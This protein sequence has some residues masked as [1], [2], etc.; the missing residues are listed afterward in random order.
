MP[1]KRLI[2]N[3][4]L[5]ASCLPD[6]P[7]GMSHKITMHTA[8]V[9]K[10][11]LVYPPTYAPLSRPEGGETTWGFVKSTGAV[12]RPKNFKTPGDEVCHI[13]DAGELSG[14]TSI[15]PTCTDLTHL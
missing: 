8:R 15:V 6:A 9:Y 14:Y 3:S 13:L 4:D 12:C 5:I 10:V 1:A 7:E 11:S 2:V